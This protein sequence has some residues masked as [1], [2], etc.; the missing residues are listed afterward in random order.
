[1]NALQEI[2]N[3]M[4]DEK[5][6]LISGLENLKDDI[7]QHA[8][9]NGV[10]ERIDFYAQKLELLLSESN[11]G[12][13]TEAAHSANTNVGRSAASDTNQSIGD[14]G[15]DSGETAVVG[16]NEQTKELCPDCGTEMYNRGIF[17]VCPLCKI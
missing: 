11:T 9:D 17:V 14:G 10:A 12:A 13:I 5:S 2:I 15:A 7:P 8:R 1:M 3:E 16:Q 4:K 6:I